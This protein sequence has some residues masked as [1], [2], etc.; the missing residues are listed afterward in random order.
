MTARPRQHAPRPFRPFKPEPCNA[1]RALRLPRPALHLGNAALPVN[2]LW[3][4][5]NWLENPPAHRGPGRP[6]H[7]ARRGSAGDRRS[8]LARTSTGTKGRSISRPAA[9]AIASRRAAAR[10]KA[11]RIRAS[12]R[13]RKSMPRSAPH[14]E[15][16]AAVYPGTCR[17][18]L[19][20]HRRRD[21]RQRAD[22]SP[23]SASTPAT[24]QSI[25]PT[26]SPVPTTSTSNTN[27]AISS[28][29]RATAPPR[30]NC[31]S[32]WTMRTWA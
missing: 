8:P 3:P 25:S 28:S 7:Q 21:A 19:R 6:A 9:S 23:P 24:R 26:S 14:A 16:G 12:A 11:A 31:P 22:G 4:R 20:D 30:T 18:R 2:W 15:D 17:G 10:P 32:S 13:A 5:Q 1:S 29:P 27:S